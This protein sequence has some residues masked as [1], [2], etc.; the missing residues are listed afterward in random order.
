MVHR[1][2]W[3]GKL[4]TT[5]DPP[6]NKCAHEIDSQYGAFHELQWLFTDKFFFPPIVSN[7]LTKCQIIIS[8]CSA[9]LLKFVEAYLKFVE[10]AR[11]GEK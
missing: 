3:I 1:T 5:F 2:K 9:L 10:N 8:C 11:F 4:G 7:F 6:K